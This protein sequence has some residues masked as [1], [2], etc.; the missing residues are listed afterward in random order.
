MKNEKVYDIT[1]LEPNTP[2]MEIG[3]NPG[4]PY[5]QSLVFRQDY[6]VVVISPARKTTEIFEITQK[7]SGIVGY[8]GKF[9]KADVIFQVTQ[10]Y[11]VKD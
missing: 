8:Y 1:E 11:E 2:Y 4:H 5:Y 9:V 6:Q 3:L 7:G 10:V